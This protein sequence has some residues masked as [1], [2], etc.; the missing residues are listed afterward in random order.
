VRYLSLNAGLPAMK[1]RILKLLV[2]RKSTGLG[3]SGHIPNV[4]SNSLLGTGIL[5][6]LGVKNGLA[7]KIGVD[8]PQSSGTWTH[9]DCHCVETIGNRMEAKVGSALADCTLCGP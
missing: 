2:G 5:N 1:K 8:R 6:E 9:S 7:K 4:F 3:I